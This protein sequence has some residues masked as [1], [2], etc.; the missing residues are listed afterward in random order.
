MTT[1]A[2]IQNSLTHFSSNDLGYYFGFDNTGVN[3]SIIDMIVGGNLDSTSP[4]ANI[5]LSTLSG[6][7]GGMKIFNLVEEIYQ[8]VTG[9][10]NGGN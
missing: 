8:F 1:N 3:S 9:D 4:F 2:F 7:I 5:G 10:P 6:R